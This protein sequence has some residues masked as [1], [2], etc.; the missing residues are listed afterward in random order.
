[1]KF[2]KHMVA[3]AG[4]C[5]LIALFVPY[6][7]VSAEGI[8]GSASAFD[9]LTSGKAVGEESKG[10]T[11][12]VFGVLA[13]KQKKLGRLPGGLAF[14]FGAVGTLFGAGLL[15]A[16]GDKASGAAAAEGVK[17]TVGAGTYLLLAGS[18]IGMLGGL[19]ALIKP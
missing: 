10:A 11:L 13:E 18:A 1:M 19:L 17:Y 5:A 8:S 3:I 16:I 2:T 9:V 12:L 14:L 15:A 7:S 6:E 4:V